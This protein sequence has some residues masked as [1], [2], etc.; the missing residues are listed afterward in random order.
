MS[1]RRTLLGVVVA[2]AVVAGCAVEAP[3]PSPSGPI[4][5]PFAAPPSSPPASPSTAVVTPQPS[6]EPATPAFTTPFPPTA[7]ASW[8]GLRWQ[9]LAAGDPLAQVR[10]VARWQ[11]GFVAVGKVVGSGTMARTPVWTSRDGASWWQLPV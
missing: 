2:A 9:R 3:T 11:G 5:S 6:T 10:S 1:R 4:R 7:S 8:T